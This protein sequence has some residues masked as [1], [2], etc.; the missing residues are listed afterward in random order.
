MPRPSATCAGRAGAWRQPLRCDETGAAALRSLRGQLLFWLVLLHL[1]AMAATAWVSY[2]IYGRVIENL[3]DKQMR[4]VADSYAGRR[5]AP[6]LQPVDDDAAL[7]RGALIL[8][9]WSP[10]GGALLASSATGVVRSVPLQAQPGCASGTEPVG[11][12]TS[13][14]MVRSGGGS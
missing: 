8:Q 12:S 4:A 11:Q 6:E 1:A 9:L 14:P 13:L 7:R 2:S 10:D 5:R 3:L